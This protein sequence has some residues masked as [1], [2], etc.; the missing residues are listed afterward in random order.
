MR[1][2]NLCPPIRLGDGVRRSGGAAHAVARAGFVDE[3]VTDRAL[4]E[5]LSG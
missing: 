5:A 2:R 3:M 4:A 1:Q